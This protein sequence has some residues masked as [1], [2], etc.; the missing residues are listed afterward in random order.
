MNPQARSIA[1][2][3]AVLFAARADAAPRLALTGKA[4]TL[5]YGFDVTYGLTEK[6]NV[7]AVFTPGPSLGYSFAQE[8]T[9]YDVDLQFRSG[10]AQL[11]WHPRAGAFHLSTGVFLNQNEFAGS[12]V[13]NS[14]YVIGD[15]TYTG[16]EIGSLEAGIGFSGVA[17][18]VG[19]GWGNAVGSGNRFGVVFDIGVLFQGSP[20]VRLAASGPISEDAEFQRNLAQEEGTIGSD[21]GIFAIYPIATLGLRCRLW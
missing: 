16:A 17:P 18:Y 4:G 6:L 19:L 5:G 10:S 21:L 7:R 15:R 8:G 14:S 13:S 3:L 1:A 2:A 20:E 11:D 9:S 12:A